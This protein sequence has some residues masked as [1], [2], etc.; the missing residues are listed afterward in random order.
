M[1]KVLAAAIAA[2]ASSLAV[3]PAA[4]ARSFYVTS[5][6]YCLHGRMANGQRVHFGAVAMNMLPL[7]TRISVSRS[8]TG[9][10]RHTVADRIGWGTQLDFWVP[11][12]AQARQ[13]GRRRVKVTV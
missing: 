4:Q 1:R 8:P 11:S 9:L 13:W 7:G 3:A 2:V 12:C 6:A 5:T 10:R